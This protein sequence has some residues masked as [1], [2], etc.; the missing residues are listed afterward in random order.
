MKTLHL[1]RTA[2][3]ISVCLP[4]GAAPLLA[5]QRTPRTP[6]DPQPMPAPAPRAQIFMNGLSFRSG[7]LLG[8]TLRPSSGAADTVGIL[9]ESVQD[10]MPAEKAGIRGGARLASIDGVD[11]RLELRDIG[12]SAAERLPETRL[13]RA[14]SAKAPGESV[15]VVVRQDGR[16][17]T[18]RI[19]LAETPGSRAIGAM[20]PSPRRMLG[21]GFAQR[22]SIRDTA[23]LLIT[24]LTEDGAGEKAGLMEGDRLVSA[25][26][27]DLRVRAADAGSPEGVEASV[28]R[29]RRALDASK[30]SQPIRL[31]V[32]SEGRRR[33]VSVMPSREMRWNGFTISPARVRDMAADIRASVDRSFALSED[34]RRELERARSEVM[35]DR[36][37]AMRDRDGAMRES[38]RELAR[39]RIEIERSARGAPRLLI[40]DGDDDGEVR[41]DRSSGGMLRGRTDGAVLS[42]DGL[43]LASVDRDFAQQLGK[44]AERGALVIR[45]R[46]SWEPLHAGDVLLSIDG[47]TVRDGDA[48]DVSI[49]R[50]RDQ[51]IEILR[52][53]KKETLTLRASR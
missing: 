40:E 18:K 6:P 15:T 19:T 49:D 12:D 29:L 4:F 8:V 38:R 2:L 32:L 13:R 45:A 39:A 9:I 48:L 33:T 35:R 28:S 50:R 10:G 26:G 47:R 3:L 30:D 43:S 37:D 46:D 14:I 7:A 27:A 41:I 53:G 1:S 44:G 11:L 5:Q 21:I 34:D 23:G 25:D 51:R 17:D 31:D 52:N 24:S 36:D 22:G 16:T 20:S 42:L